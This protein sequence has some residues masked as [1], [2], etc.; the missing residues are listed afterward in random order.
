MSRGSNGRLLW[1]RLWIFGVHKRRGIPSLAERATIT[2]SGMTSQFHAALLTKWYPLSHSKNSHIHDS[3]QAEHATGLHPEPRDSSPQPPTPFLMMTTMI[4]IA[5]IIFFHHGLVRR[6]FRLLN[7]LGFS[8][9]LPSFAPQVI[10]SSDNLPSYN[11]LQVII[12]FFFAFSHLFHLLC[13]LPSF[14]TSH[15]CID[16]S[17]QGYPKWLNERPDQKFYHYHFNFFYKLFLYKPEGRGFESRRGHWIFQ[18]T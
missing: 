13:L 8:G 1:T 4:L 15:A 9:Y 3:V 10:D 18:L 12:P 2:F 6:L 16:V 5:I 7:L 14:Y 17:H 11:S